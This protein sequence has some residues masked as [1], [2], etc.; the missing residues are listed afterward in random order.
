MQRLDEERKRELLELQR[1]Q[2]EKD[3]ARVTLEELDWATPDEPT[4]TQDEKVPV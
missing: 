4:R 3:R 1:R 2:A